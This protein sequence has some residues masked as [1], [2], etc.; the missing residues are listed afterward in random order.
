MRLARGLAVVALLA[1]LTAGV[2]GQTR[3]FGFVFDDEGYVLGAPALRDGLTGDSVAWALTSQ[4]Y[5][6]WFPL[7]RLSLLV[8]AALF[9]VRPG[10][11]HA[12][13]VALHFAGAV[14]LWLALAGATGARW[15]S[16]AVAALWAAHP[17]QVESV[18]WVSERSMVLAGL[19]L[20]T[21]VAAYVRYVR[22]PDA[23][24]YLAVFLCV[25]LGLLA[26][27]ILATLPVLLLL[28][29]WWPLGRIRRTA[30]GAL[31]GSAGAGAGT[32]VLTEKAPL[33]L[34]C[35]AFGALA[36]R[37]QAAAGTMASLG[38][39][40]LADRVGNALRGFAWY[41][42]KAVWPAGLGVYYPLAGAGGSWWTM[43]AAALLVAGLSWLAVG[44]SRRHPHLL[45]G[46]LWCAVVLAPV[47]GVL[48]AG[49][50]AT[51]D[52]YM[53]VPLAGLVVAAVWS[54]AAAGARSPRVAAAGIAVVGVAAV[55]LAAA[56]H[57]QARFWRDEHMLFA[58][59]IAVGGAAS[60]I[61]SYRFATACL[62]AGDLEAAE[63]HYR[64]TVRLAPASGVAEHGL[65][66]ALVARGKHA[67]A[68][69]HFEAAVRKAPRYADAHR[70]LGKALERAGRPEEAA[71][72]YAQ[73]V[74]V[75]P[76]STE[77][78]TLLA[79]ILEGLGRPAAA[80]ACRREAERFGPGAGAGP[81][82]PKGEG[83]LAAAAAR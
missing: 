78:F 10:P 77:S 32:L 17:L 49:A 76:A 6:N 14:A 26:K 34:L 11:M 52:R 33:L 12:V 18:A 46:W 45:V 35:A 70:S 55:A 75:E 36:V 60:D 53:Y 66:R 72:A 48:Q 71:R 38:A 67:E 69:E 39:I 73:S 63:R 47:S 1:A 5:G 41:L 81:V 24:R 37:T 4:E 15:P 59:A 65:A 50:Q 79:G 9:G 62:A 68:V 43:A 16:A 2:Y 19:L 57:A 29:D 74:R 8:D 7:T 82:S 58:R 21:T 28:L 56:A 23:A 3:G 83:A 64:D 31:P 30:R 61:V 42:G 80:A 44:L 25:L 40:P 27:P 20:W 54:L 51:A 13:N 22:K